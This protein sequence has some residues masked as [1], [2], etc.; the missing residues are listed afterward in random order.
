MEWG[1]GL[2][3]LQIIDASSQ[4]PAGGVQVSGKRFSATNIIGQKKKKKRL[5][6]VQL[7]KLI[8]PKRK[9]KI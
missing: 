7:K 9:K 3:L 2:K 8:F 5:I 1:R 4:K 6:K